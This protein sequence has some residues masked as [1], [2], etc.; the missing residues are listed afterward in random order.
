M[1]TGLKWPSRG[2]KH[3]YVFSG[4]YKEQTT[5]W[6]VHKF[7]TDVHHLYSITYKLA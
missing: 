4:I 5:D 3:G 7:Y 1:H 6:I 2:L